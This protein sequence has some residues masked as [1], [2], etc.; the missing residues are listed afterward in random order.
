MP[1]SDAAKNTMLDA[2]PDTV[3]VAF[4]S[5]GAPGTGT[6]VTPSTLWGAG[7]RPALVLGAAASGARTPDGTESLGTIDVASQEVTHIA[8]YDAST[9]GNL[10]GHEAY[11]RTFV[12]T[13]I[14]EYP[15]ANNVFSLSDS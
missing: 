7:N 13:D 5:G 10:L 14:V 3:Y 9:A 11:S 4:F 6:E 12:A 15:D 2:L 8:Y 1:L